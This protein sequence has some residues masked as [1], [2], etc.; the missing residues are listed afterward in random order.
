MRGERERNEEEESDPQFLRSC[1][2]NL[3]R[4]NPAGWPDWLCEKTLDGLEALEFGEVRPIFQRVNAANKRD[5]TDRRLMLQAV[6]MVRFRRIAYGMKL[7]PALEEVAEVIATSPETIKSWEGRLKREIP[8]EV[9]ETLGFA[10]REASDVAHV[11]REGR[12]SHSVDLKLLEHLLYGR[13]ALE[14]LGRA[15]R[16]ARTRK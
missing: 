1:L 7:T 4:C 2:I 9:A 10:E 3:I 11:L 14:K 5:L 16:A 13:K 6:A 12:L 15:F 8:L